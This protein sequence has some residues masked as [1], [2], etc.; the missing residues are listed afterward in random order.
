MRS[1]YLT[2]HLKTINSVTGLTTRQGEDLLVRR[3]K[4][5]IGSRDINIRGPH[6][7]N[8]LPRELKNA[9]SRGGS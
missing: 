4:T 9:G 7:Y 3:S 6:L 2:S 8:Q 5:D 1:L